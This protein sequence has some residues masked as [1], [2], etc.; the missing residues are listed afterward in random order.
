MLSDADNVE[1][2]LLDIED[3]VREEVAM[4]L[5]PDNS[6]GQG[7]TGSQPNQPTGHEAPPVI[8]PGQSAPVDARNLEDVSKL[9]G[10][11]R[12]RAILRNS[13]KQK[14]LKK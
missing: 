5:K 10:P 4:I 13:M 12:S 9:T 1:E 3:F 7:G 2:A 8:T 11:A 6:G 14:V